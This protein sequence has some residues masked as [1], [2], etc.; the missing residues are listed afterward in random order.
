M[1]VIGPLIVCLANR[2]PINMEV[3]CSCQVLLETKDSR[4]GGYFQSII[5][6]RSVS[7]EI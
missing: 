3:I 6:S 2:T 1:G 7:I 4:N 5:N